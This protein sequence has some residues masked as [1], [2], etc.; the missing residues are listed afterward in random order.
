[1]SCVSGFVFV[2]VFV[3]RA[4]VMRMFVIRDLIASASF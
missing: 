3:M 4:L 1:M 2:C